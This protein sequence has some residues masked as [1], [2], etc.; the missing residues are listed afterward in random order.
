[1]GFFGEIIQKGPFSRDFQK[2]LENRL[3]QMDSKGL[4][5]SGWMLN[6]S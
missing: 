4:S 5:Q 1:M 2:F 6:T 3:S